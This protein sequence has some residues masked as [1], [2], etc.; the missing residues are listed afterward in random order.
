M[1]DRNHIQPK[2]WEPQHTK[3]LTDW[4]ARGA[5]ELQNF[6]EAFAIKE[7]V[8]NVVG[9]AL[10]DYQVREWNGFKREDLRNRSKE[11][12]ETRKR[13]LITAYPG[14]LTGPHGVMLKHAD[15]VPL[16]VLSANSPVPNKP[17]DLKIAIVLWA[18]GSAK[19]ALTFLNN[20][21]DK[22]ASFDAFI[23]DGL[24]TSKQNKFAV[25]EKGKGFILAMQ[26][27]VEK[28]ET[29]WK[30]LPKPGRGL[31]QPGASFRVGE[32]IGE[33]KWKA[34]CSVGMPDWLQVSLDDLTTRTV[35]EYLPHKYE[36]D[37]A[38]SS[39]G[40]DPE[41]YN[42]TFETAQNIL[43]QVEK[44]R[45]KY[46]LA[47]GGKSVVQADEVCITIIG[48]DSRIEVESLFSAVYG[49]IPPSRAWRPL[50]A[51][52]NLRNVQFFL[53]DGGGAPKFYLRDQLVLQ[54]VHLNKLSINYHGD[55]DVS[56]ERVMVSDNE[57]QKQYFA[58]LEASADSAFRTLPDLA[59]ELALDILT[60][61]R[62]DSLAGILSPK[63]TSGAARYR[64]AFD[65]AML[66]ICPPE[67]PSALPLYPCGPG[68]SDYLVEELGFKPFP[69]SHRAH[70]II[71]ASG[72]YTTIHDKACSLLLASPVASDIKGLDR[73]RAVLKM[74]LPAQ[75]AIEPEAITI[76]K[77]PKTQPIV[78]W[79]HEKRL[80]AFAMPTPCEDPKHIADSDDGECFCW[81]IPML[82][83]VARANWNINTKKLWHAHALC[84][85]GDLA[86]LDVEGRYM[87]MDVDQEMPAHVQAAIQEQ[88]RTHNIIRI[89]PSGSRIQPNNAGSNTQRPASA[90]VSTTKPGSSSTKSSSVNG[91]TGK[92]VPAQQQAAAAVAQSTS[93]ANRFTATGPANEASVSTST[94][95]SNSAP[96]ANQA[97][98]NE[99]ALARVIAAVRGHDAL[100]LKLDALQLKFDALQL[101]SDN[102]YEELEQSKDRVGE[103]NK[104]VAE[105]EKAN[106]ALNDIC[107]FVDS[108]QKQRESKRQKTQ[109]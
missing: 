61:D 8:Q 75:D 62:S 30:N 60:D 88:A 85:R 13:D 81:M 19:N 2:S 56:S 89:P 83:A 95:T 12:R 57:K 27:L 23:V 86:N 44:R 70:A 4:K 68:D 7:L 28:V 92:A 101:K 51:R 33:F 65:A 22:N 84:V 47:V 74:T 16:Y 109:V 79:D 32:Q 45:E 15:C 34:S 24:S 106:R 43:E 52:N 58:D 94:S 98:M 66:R 53:A 54:G 72:A 64:A 26:Y 77:Y 50:G 21:L 108:V 90:S 76:R 82:E 35:D 40:G 55:L 96:T 102:Q 69:V 41:V 39:D 25:G 87:S 107:E 36:L 42:R 78:V 9:Q 1:S 5:A 63:N 97:E 3:P 38:H 104:Q 10:K 100:Q 67:P 31:P 14:L 93:A 105:L 99:D 20:H 46:G 17:T 80:V 91:A 48:L 6:D 59:I 29:L 18:T 71:R 103:L 73:L 37:L 11:Q 49:I